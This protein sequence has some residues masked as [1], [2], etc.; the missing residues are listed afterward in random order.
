MPHQRRRE[1][2]SRFDGEAQFLISIEAGGESINLQHSCHIMANYDLPWNP[3]RL[4]K[5]IGRLYRYGLWY[6][7]SRAGKRQP[8]FLLSTSATPPKQF[9][10]P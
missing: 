7:R 5:R 10:K 8:G 9:W 3:M 6:H 1:A 2:I 4:V